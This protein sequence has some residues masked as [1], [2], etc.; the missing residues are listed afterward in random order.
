MSEKMKRPKP[1]HV[2][3]LENFPCKDFPEVRKAAKAGDATIYV[4]A[5]APFDWAQMKEFSPTSPS[6]ELIRNLAL[7]PFIAILGFIIYAITAKNFLLLLALP[8]FWVGFAIVYADPTRYSTG[9]ANLPP[10]VRTIGLV[11]NAAVVLILFGLGWSLIQRIDWVAA[12][13]LTLA[14]IWLSQWMGDKKIAEGFSK[15]VWEYEELFCLLWV[16]GALNVRFSNGNSYLIDCRKENGQYSYF[17]NA[18]IPGM[19][20]NARALGNV[21]L[22]KATPQELESGSI[23]DSRLADIKI[24]SGLWSIRLG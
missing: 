16:S 14:I 20:E 1:K 22:A 23:P 24:N 8:L 10:H 6:K 7:A 18:L 13:T 9:K 2:Q 12:V 5:G 21:L 11:R 4:H 15:A 19:F 3:E 17:H